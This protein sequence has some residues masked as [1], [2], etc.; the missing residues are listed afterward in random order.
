MYKLS[1]MKNYETGICRWCGEKKDEN[2]LWTQNTRGLCLMGPDTSFKDSGLAQLEKN[3][4]KLLEALEKIAKRPTYPSA[5]ESSWAQ[6]IA[7][8]AINEALKRE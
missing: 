4:P 6:E 5:W 8:K 2:H 1:D 3:A 7:K